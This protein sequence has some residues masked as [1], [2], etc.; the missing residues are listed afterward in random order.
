MTYRPNLTYGE[1]LYEN[2]FRRSLATSYDGT[3][4][5]G[6]GYVNAFDWADFSL[7]A[8]ELSA[9]RRLTFSFP[10]NTVFDTFA[11]Y[12]VPFETYDLPDEAIIGLA[13]IGEA[14][15]GQSNGSCLVSLELETGA[16]TGIYTTIATHTFTSTD[17]LWM[18]HLPALYAIATTE[19]VR[20]RFTNSA[21]SQLV[22]R[23][24]AIGQRLT[25][26][27]G[28]QADIAP[29]SLTSNVVLSNSMSI[30]GSLLGR[31]SRQL[32]K[33]MAIELNPVTKEWVRG[34]WEPFAKHAVN[35]PFYYSWSPINYPE[36]ACLA[37]A[38][39]IVAPTNTTPVPH[40][41]CS[42]PLRVI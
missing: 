39:E 34:Y 38:T 1:V 21:G 17:Q 25:F 18:A 31:Q 23:D 4:I 36:D 22:V 14:Q 40:M 11:I 30:N 12:V 42:M 26:E 13:L 6:F 10:F 16:G 15:I 3:E 35:K 19:R 37:S 8:T 29:P 20:V 33:T 32:A 24:M 41:K 7:F 9:D 5:S 27:M 28:Q 2:A